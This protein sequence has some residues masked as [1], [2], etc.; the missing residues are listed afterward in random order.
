MFFLLN[1]VIWPKEQINPR[2]PGKSYEF[3]K[4]ELTVLPD[5]VHLV[6][7]WLALRNKEY[8]KFHLKRQIVLEYF[9]YVKFSIQISDDNWNK[10]ETWL[11]QLN[12]SCFWTYHFS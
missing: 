7:K 11:D 12:A 3:P 5:S 10:E 4:A 6:A 9:F 8:Q 1:W 2:N